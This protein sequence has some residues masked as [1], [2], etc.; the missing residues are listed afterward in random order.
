MEKAGVERRSYIAGRYKNLLDPFLPVN[1][2]AKAHID[3]SLQDTHQAFIQNV[4]EGRGTRLKENE[5]LF[6]GLFWSGN[7]AL[8]L[9]LIDG[10]AD[11]ERIAKEII[12]AKELVDY[13]PTLTLIDKISRRVGASMATKVLLEMGLMEKGLR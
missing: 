3:H 5:L 4:R 9:G 11:A 6:T 8:Q 13:S 1:P 12:Q 10:F 2:E 7:E